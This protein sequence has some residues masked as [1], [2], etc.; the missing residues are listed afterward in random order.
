MMIVK[1]EIIDTIKPIFKAYLDYISQFYEIEHHNAWCN[2]ALK[3]LQ[4]YSVEPDHHMYALIKSESI[5]GF[6]MVNKHFRFNTDGFAI[7]EFYIQKEHEK[8]GYGRTLAE[9]V[10]EQHKG[11][12]EVAVS[13]KNNL[14]HK[15]WIQVLSSYTND[16]F[17]EKKASSFNGPCFIFSTRPN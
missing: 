4:K 8:K 16:T 1:L 15:F 9:H 3:N 6:A 13:S 14:A 7:A 11:P 17:Q 5:I 10:F 2:G 12:W